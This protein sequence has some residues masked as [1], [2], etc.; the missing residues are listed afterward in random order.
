[1]IVLVVRTP[2]PLVLWFDSLQ[3]HQES[4]LW[5][6][7]FCFLSANLATGA[8]YLYF[9]ATKMR[10]QILRA[11]KD[12]HRVFFQRSRFRIITVE[13]CRQCTCVALLQTG[14]VCRVPLNE[15]DRRKGPAAENDGV[16]ALE[17]ANVGLEVWG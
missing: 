9:S 15:V 17:M 14:N 11:L 5:V 13:I 3:L 6:C 16:A 10:K 4:L 12:F 2:Q 7:A 1:M 8:M